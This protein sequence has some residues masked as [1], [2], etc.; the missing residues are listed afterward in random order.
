MEGCKSRTHSQFLAKDF[1][2]NCVTAVKIFVSLV[3]YY[4][5]TTYLVSVKAHHKPIIM[6]A[7]CNR[8]D[9]YIFI[10]FLM[11]GLCNRADH[12][13]FIL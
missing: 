11:V 9:H 4:Y 13:I 8:T 6:V 10:L 12:N 5:N 2:V 3:K 7:L 1:T